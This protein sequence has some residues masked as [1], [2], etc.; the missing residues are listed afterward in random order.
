MRGFLAVLMKESIHMRRDKGTLRL[1]I[2][3]PLFQMILFG[4][5]DTNIK[6]VRTAGYD[7]CRCPH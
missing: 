7:Q 3:I 6:H 4:S 5:I 2:F 1:A